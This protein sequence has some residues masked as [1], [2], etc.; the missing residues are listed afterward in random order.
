M[1]P[2]GAADDEAGGVAGD[3]ASWA[4]APAAALG[5]VARVRGRLARP[6]TS[7]RASA[8]LESAG[9]ERW[10]SERSTVTGGRQRRGT[11][12]AM[13]TQRARSRRRSVHGEGDVE[14]DVLAQRIPHRA[15]RRSRQ[16][17]GARSS[18]RRSRRPS[19]STWRSMAVKRPDGPPAR[20]PESDRRTAVAGTRDFFRKWTMSMPMQPPNAMSSACIGEGPPAPSL[21]SVIDASRGVAREPKVAGPLSSARSGGRS[22]G[23]DPSGTGDPADDAAR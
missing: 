11:C 18:A 12:L 6:A 14:R 10:S 1:S 15:V 5:G 19:S 16:L 7:R 2:A 22:E 8:T 13:V 17:D 23:P 4:G 21:S 3:A 20:R 9:C